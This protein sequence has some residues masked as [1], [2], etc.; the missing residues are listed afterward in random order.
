MGVVLT[1]E[2]AAIEQTALCA[3]C[4]QSKNLIVLSAGM[5]DAHGKQS[6]ACDVHFRDTRDLVLGWAIFVANQEA[7]GL[8]T[9]GIDGGEYGQAPLY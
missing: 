2:G 4:R 3:I 7:V 6:F 1:P 9:Y 5:R 8:Y